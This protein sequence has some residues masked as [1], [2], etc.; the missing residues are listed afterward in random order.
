MSYLKKLIILVS[1]IIILIVGLNI[2]IDYGRKTNNDFYNKVKKILP[3]NF[4]NFLIKKYLF[5]FS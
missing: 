1:T 2:F 3:Q 5:Y 4:K